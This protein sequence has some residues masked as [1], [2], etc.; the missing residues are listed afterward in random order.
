MRP[1]RYALQGKVL[2]S[3]N[4]DCNIYREHRSCTREVKFE[5]ST[6]NERRWRAF[7]LASPKRAYPG[8]KISEG[9][10]C[11]RRPLQKNAAHRFSIIAARGR[12]ITSNCRACN[13][14]ATWLCHDVHV[15]AVNSG[16]PILNGLGTGQVRTLSNSLIWRTCHSTSS[17]WYVFCR[18]N[19]GK[20]RRHEASITG[21]H[22]RG[23]CCGGRWPGRL[24]RPGGCRSLCR[25]AQALNPSVLQYLGISRRLPMCLC[26]M[27]VACIEVI[28]HGRLAVGY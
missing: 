9:I 3:L 8:T 28:V 2:C 13:R 22:L 24:C 6:A 12:V 5:P 18:R 10:F 27:L 15:R 14:G 25:S 19:G 21:G 26:D 11:H 20:V 23:G 1:S 7:P 16:Q 17:Y 4:V